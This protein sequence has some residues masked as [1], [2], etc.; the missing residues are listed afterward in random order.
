MLSK[1]GNKAVMEGGEGENPKTK[2]CSA[3]AI[4]MKRRQQE[5]E[6]NNHKSAKGIGEQ[7]SRWRRRP[8]SIRERKKEG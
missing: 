8:E 4:G 7:D 2:T 5:Q 1:E 3:S 6:K